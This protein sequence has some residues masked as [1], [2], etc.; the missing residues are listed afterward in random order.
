MTE[1]KEKEDAGTAFGPVKYRIIRSARRTLSMQINCNGEVTVR[2]P[3]HTSDA[4]I[5]R[6]IA[7]HH[8]WLEKH[9]RK[10]AAAEAAADEDGRLTEEELRAL[11]KEALRE[12]PPRVQYWA[13]RMGVSYRN[14]T[15][16]NQRTRWGSCSTQGNLNF[17]CLLMLTPPEV[18]DSVIVHE[19]AHRKH[20]NHSPA[21]YAFILEFCP[22]YKEYNRWLKQNGPVLMKRMTG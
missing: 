5:R 18:R 19:L 22:N 8:T 13:E 17:N 14:I 1:V 4:E 2:A 15:I 16:R 3:F 12:I 20:M 11:G 6:F 21:F 7:E 9:L 10:A